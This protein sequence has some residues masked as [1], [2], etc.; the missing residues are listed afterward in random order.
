MNESETTNL[1]ILKNHAM[2]GRAKT[3]SRKE[4]CGVRGVRYVMPY[5]SYPTP[6]FAALRELSPCFILNRL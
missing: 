4:R 5:T 3:Q 6:F 1:R 2:R